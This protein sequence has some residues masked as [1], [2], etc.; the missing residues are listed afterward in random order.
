MQMSSVNLSLGNSYYFKTSN[1][2]FRHIFFKIVEISRYG[3]IDLYDIVFGYVHLQNCLETSFQ[4]DLSL[5]I[6][7]VEFSS[8]MCFCHVNFITS[9]S[10]F[11]TVDNF[12]CI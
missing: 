6:F 1:K 8:S 2:A 5:V 7:L 12:L 10:I 9:L 11:I 3:L 4:F